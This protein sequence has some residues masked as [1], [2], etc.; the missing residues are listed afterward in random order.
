MPNQLVMVRMHN[1][2]IICI[3]KVRFYFTEDTTTPWATTSQVGVI[4]PRNYILQGY[5]NF[6]IYIYM[7]PGHW[8]NELTVHQWPRRMGFNTKSYQR[9]KNGT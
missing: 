3:L 1:R 6:W 4:H 8:P 7:M 2:M 9:L 5:G